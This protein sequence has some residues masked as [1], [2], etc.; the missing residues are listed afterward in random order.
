ML[1]DA[2]DAKFWAHHVPQLGRSEPVIWN[3]MLA[4]GCLYEHPYVSSYPI[5][6]G[7][8]SR[9][10]G[11]YQRSVLRWHNKAIADLK[12]CMAHETVIL[13][14]SVLASKFG[15]DRWQGHI[16]NLVPT[17][18]LFSSD[19][20]GARSTLYTLMD[21]CHAFMSLLGSR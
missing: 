10:A 21:H 18:D 8:A 3:A 17:S 1:S 13:R 9:L 15:V 6:F 7:E 4:I 12:I 5:E 19:L 16:G 14:H 20:Q 11:L 2:L